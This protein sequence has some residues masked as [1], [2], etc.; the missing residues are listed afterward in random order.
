LEKKLPIQLEENT[1]EQIRPDRRGLVYDLYQGAQDLNRNLYAND[2]E[3]SPYQYLNLMGQNLIE[4]FFVLINSGLNSMDKQPGNGCY[5]DAVFMPTDVDLFEAW[6]VLYQKFLVENQHRPS[7]GPVGVSIDNFYFKHPQERRLNHYY[8][9]RNDNSR[10]GLW[11][12]FRKTRV[13]TM[14]RL[15]LPQRDP[16]DQDIAPN[17]ICR[18]CFQRFNKQSHWSAHQKTC[19]FDL[20]DEEAQ[21][22]INLAVEN[23]KFVGIELKSRIG[24]TDMSKIHWTKFEIAYRRYSA[25]WAVHPYRGI[26]NPDKCRVWLEKISKNWKN[27]GYKIGD[28]RNISKLRHDELTMKIDE[29]RQDEIVSRTPA[30]SSLNM[31]CKK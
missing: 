15:S 1:W 21:L 4:V 27:N 24:W 14:I 11:T 29:K 3:R 12:P 17:N 8:K 13:E 30:I 19:Y 20:T 9:K 18:F 6:F 23:T 26:Y 7:G 28:D 5:G 31:F 25:S 22:Y 2:K 16:F 10:L